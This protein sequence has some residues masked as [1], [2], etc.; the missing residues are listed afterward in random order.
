M[1]DGAFS[2]EGVIGTR[3]I[4]VG[5]PKGWMTKSIAYR[6]R[7]VS[8]TS[9]DFREGAGPG[10]L[11]IVL[12]NQITVVSGTVQGGDGQPSADFEVVVFPDDFEKVRFPSRR[13]SSAKPDQQ[14]L[15]RIEQLPPGDYHAVAL[16]DVDEEMR[17]DPEYLARLRPLATAFTIGEGQTRSLNLKLVAALP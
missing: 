17:F 10:R 5:P 4:T 6:G 13:L 2:L 3:R 9:V 16:A 7:D 11:Q 8:E 14:G 12:T 1:A 15:Y